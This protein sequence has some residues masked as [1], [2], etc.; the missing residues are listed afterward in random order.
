MSNQAGNLVQGDE[1]SAGSN[2]VPS[3]IDLTLN[4]EEALSVQAALAWYERANLNAIYKLHSPHSD[5]CRE[6]LARSVDIGRRLRQQRRN[7][8]WVDT[9]QVAL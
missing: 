4:A 5:K 1:P 6:E 9:P 3:V 7:N 2:P 8:S